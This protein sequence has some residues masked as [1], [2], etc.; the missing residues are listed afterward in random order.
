MTAYERKLE[1]I[2]SLKYLDLFGYASAHGVIPY[3]YIGGHR[4]DI[5]RPMLPIWKDDPEYSG[6]N[7]SGYWMKEYMASHLAG[8]MIHGINVSN[9]RLHCPGK[10]QKN[11]YSFITSQIWG[12]Y[13]VER[14]IPFDEIFLHDADRK[15][16]EIIRNTLK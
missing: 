5:W 11:R 2:E 12:A 1:W 4:N 14:I 8:V 7:L 9:Q 10:V 3:L 16:I 13:V 6:H 15:T